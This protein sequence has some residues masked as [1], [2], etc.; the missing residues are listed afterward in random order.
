MANTAKKRAYL[1]RRCFG[2]C[3]VYAKQNGSCR[4]LL[5]RTRFYLLAFPYLSLLY[6]SICRHVALCSVPC[7]YRMSQ[8]STFNLMSERFHGPDCVGAFYITATRDVSL[9]RTETHPL[10]L[11]SRTGQ[12][13]CLKC[14]HYFL[15]VFLTTAS[16]TS[17]SQ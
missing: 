5:C 7:T 3:F 15:C 13:V 1:E 6:L 4:R 10:G 9:F 14:M 17:I 11:S 16:V 12:Y 2:G 8:V